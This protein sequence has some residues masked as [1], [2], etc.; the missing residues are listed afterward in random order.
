MAVRQ[1]EGNLLI[2]PEKEAK[3]LFARLDLA[4]VSD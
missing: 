2:S 3:A 1:V 4:A